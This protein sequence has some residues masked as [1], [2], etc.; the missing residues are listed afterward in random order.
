MH[1]LWL[2]DN[3]Y[4]NRG[5][6]AQSCDRIVHNLRQKG[7]KIDVLHFSTRATR[8]KINPTQ[9][10]RDIAFPLEEDVPHTL[11]LV[12]NFLENQNISY[13]HLIAFGGYTPVLSGPLFSAWLDLPLVTFFRGNDFDVAIFTLKRKDALE[14]CLEKSAAI[15]VVSQDKGRKIQKLFPTANIHF[16][17]N[18]LDAQGWQ[19][20]T[21]DFEKAKAWRQENIQNHQKVI[22]LFGHLK[23]KK[24]ALFFFKSLKISGFAHKIHLLVTGEMSENVEA[25][26]TENQAEI[27]YSHYPFMDRYELIPYYLACDAISIPSFYDGMPNVLLE[28]GLLGIPMIASNVAGMADVLSE[29][30]AF[31]FPA[32]DWQACKE[33]IF[34][35]SQTSEEN[36]KQMGQNLQ[37]LL[38]QNYTEEQ[39][40]EGYLEILKGI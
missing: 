19:A 17:P 29:K 30:E 9:N 14:K 12:W 27:S 24:G 2:T 10:G 4:P 40:T 8:L 25:F 13:S 26:L 11:N 7:V 15:C 33:A 36:L 20:S 32:S 37:T 1:L 39:E 38:T 23:A 31:L 28:A 22:G 34:N 6:M 35:F 3:F 5:G 16:T 21:S 18:G